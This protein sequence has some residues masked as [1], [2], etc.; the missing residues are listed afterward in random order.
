V[1]ALDGTQ[2]SELLPDP[3]AILPYL[4]LFTMVTLNPTDV[5]GYKIPTMHLPDLSIIRGQKFVDTRSR[6]SATA[7][8][9]A[10]I[11]DPL[12]LDANAQENLGI[13][14]LSSEDQG[15]QEQRYWRLPIPLGAVFTAMTTSFA[16]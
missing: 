2:V 12:A 6:T 16:Y 13:I 5:A 7:R 15:F 8:N 11:F 1:N 4:G 3:Q 10:R 14:P 9:V